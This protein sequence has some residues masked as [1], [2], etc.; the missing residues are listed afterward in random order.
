MLWKFFVALKSWV[1]VWILRHLRKYFS[2]LY[3]CFAICCLLMWKRWLFD[4]TSLL[5]D[6]S[7]SGNCR[8]IQTKLISTALRNTWSHKSAGDSP[9]DDVDNILDCLIRIFSLSFFLSFFLFF[10]PFVLIKAFH[11]QWVSNP[12][13]TFSVIA[14]NY[15]FNIVFIHLFFF[16]RI[17]L[18]KSF[19]HN[20]PTRDS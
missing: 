11:F 16:G 18:V 15:F 19:W 5:S 8:G 6:S 1:S 12:L 10:P 13:T 14:E 17:L 9:R 7:S 2:F 3:Q 4:D 20:V